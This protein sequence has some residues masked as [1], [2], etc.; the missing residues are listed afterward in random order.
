VTSADVRVPT[1][2]L[3]AVLA[4]RTECREQAIQQFRKFQVILD[5]NAHANMLQ[6]PQL[7]MGRLY[8]KFSI[9]KLEDSAF[10]S[11]MQDL[12]AR[13][14]EIR[15]VI[16]DDKAL[17]EAYQQAQELPTWGLSMAEVRSEWL[18]AKS[19][20]LALESKGRS[21]ASEMGTAD[22]LGPLPVIPAEQ[23]L[24]PGRRNLQV[25]W[26][27][28]ALRAG[29]AKGFSDFCLDEL[30]QSPVIQPWLRC[31]VLAR[32]AISNGRW[33]TANSEC[34]AV[35]QNSG[36]ELSVTER[37]AQSTRVW[38]QALLQYD[39]T[40][41]ENER[42]VLRTYLESYAQA[43]R[44]SGAWF[45][46]EY[47]ALFDTLLGATFVVALAWIWLIWAATVRRATLRRF[48]A[49]CVQSD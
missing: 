20:T 9:A 8:A 35:Q 39:L 10:G 37:L 12:P 15:K 19:R 28:I 18:L 13:L 38:D 26:C 45:R 30:A 1:G 7:K 11:T 25:A 41:T 17:L 33:R 22:V 42:R 21:L 4:W 36:Q 43:S 46:H 3:A 47:A 5:H 31:A 29:V 49:P 23:T 14:E 40:A 27:A 44:R 2:L 34:D 16:T 32:A 48:L 24:S 6:D